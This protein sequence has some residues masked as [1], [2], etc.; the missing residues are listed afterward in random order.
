MR[1]GVLQ[2]NAIKHNIIQM[3]I[4]IVPKLHHDTTLNVTQYNIRK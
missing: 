1:N 2:L 4:Y 3:Y